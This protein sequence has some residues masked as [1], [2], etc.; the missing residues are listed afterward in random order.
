MPLKKDSIKFFLLIKIFC[1][2][3]KENKKK[4]TVTIENL[5]ARAEKGSLLS[6]NGFVVINAEDQRIIKINGNI[7]VIIFYKPKS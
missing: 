6:I 3:Y 4:P 5:K 7:L 1:F 2:E